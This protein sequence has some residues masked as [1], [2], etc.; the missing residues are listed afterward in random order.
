[1]GLEQLSKQLLMDAKKEANTVISAAEKEKEK[2]ISD[3]EEK[4]RQLLSEA[5][6]KAKEMA[7][8]QKSE[9]LSGASIR[10]KQIVDAEKNAVVEKA[11]Q[12]VFAEISL[13]RETK[14][15]DKLLRTLAE[16]GQKE[17]GKESIIIVNEK[18]H[19]VAKKLFPHLSKET[20]PITGGAIV[21]TKDGKIRVDNSFEAIFEQN[22]DWLKREVFE[23]M[24]AGKDKK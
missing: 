19:G 22:K 21:S 20:A 2:I 13:V 14:Q 3:A 1:M 10:A 23:E 8:R 16:E 6:R 17:L 7:Q 5:K 9:L 4:K 12:A 18:D 15:Y 24:F 11:L